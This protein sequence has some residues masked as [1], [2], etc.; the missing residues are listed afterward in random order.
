MQP[1]LHILV[2]TRISIKT[3]EG[4]TRYGMYRKESPPKTNKITSIVWNTSY[5]AVGTEEI[6]SV[7]GAM[8][9]VGPEARPV[10]LKCLAIS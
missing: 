2:S 9:P 5:W 8:W 4:I 10:S 1:P 7:A 3:K 6:T